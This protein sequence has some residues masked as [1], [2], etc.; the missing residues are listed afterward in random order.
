MNWVDIIIIIILI[1]SF[2]GGL[3]DGAVKSFFSLVALII[4]IPC[5]G[6]IYRIIASLIS[7][8][9]GTDWE[10]IIGFFIAMGIISI[11]L[12]LIFLLPRKLI[13][14]IWG[15]GVLF[16]LIGGVINVLNA[17]IGLVVLAL[18]LRTYPVISWLETAFSKS[19]VLTS[20]IDMFG[21]VQ[22]LLPEVFQKATT[23]VAII[24]G[25]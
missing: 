1:L 4:A 14:K 25:I 7:L 23:L 3:K 2:L 5:A 19:A 15:Q 18:V 17:S 21:F 9:P 16:R 8:L 10:N 20:L 24:N 22:A 13:Q 11:I 12:H 6:L